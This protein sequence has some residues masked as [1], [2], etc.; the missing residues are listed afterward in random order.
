MTD[1]DIEL[2][3]AD[4]AIVLRGV[5]RD[6]VEP[7]RAGVARN[8]ASPSPLERTVR[9]ADGSAAFF[10]DYCNW[11][12]IPE[13][14]AFVFESPAAAL[15]ARLMRSKTA[16]FFHEHVLVKDPGTSVVTPWHQD[17]PYYCVDGGQ[18]V[19]LWIALD[20]VARDTVMECVAGSHLWGKGFKP[21]RFDGTPLYPNDNLEAIPDIDARRGELRILGW[22]LEP[23]DAIA[24]T[25]RTVHGAPANTASRPRRA[26]SARWVGD[27]A[28][29]A[30][31]AG[32]TSPP[33]PNLKLPAGA[34]LDAP[35]F[36]LVHSH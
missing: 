16:R 15:A 18:S 30:V 31:R 26:F 24:F 10:Q 36:P 6:W 33:F 4:G 22:E 2:F 8:R 1:A 11:Q 23:G 13:Y 19:S 5:F 25:F 21:M 7:L 14:R 34:P 28:V 3:Q 17:Q 12:R 35:E 27:D 20:P 32:R 9:P 29:F